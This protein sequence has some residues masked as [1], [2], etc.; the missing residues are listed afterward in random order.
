MAHDHS[1]PQDPKPHSPHDTSPSKTSEHGH[2]CQHHDH[3]HHQHK[4]HEHHDH[5][6]LAAHEIVRSLGQ[7]D[8][9]VKRIRWALFLNGSFAVIELIGG[10][11]TGSYAIVADAVHDFGDALSLLLA[12]LYQK[13]SL[14]AADASYPHGYG[15][16]SIVSSL[17]TGLVIIGGSLLVI[18]GALQSLWNGETRPF[19]PGM[20]A[21]AVLGIVVNGFAALGLA[22]GHSHNE[23]ILTWHL[24]ED[25]LGWVCVLL[26]AVLIYFLHWN[27]IDP[28]LALGLAVFVAYNVLKN[29]KEPY[30][31]ILQKAPDLA[32]QKQHKDAL[33]ALGVSEITEWRSWSLDGF[34]H[35]LTLKL[36]IEGTQ[37]EDL[38]KN[39]IRHY[40]KAHGYRSITIE[41]DPVAS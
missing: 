8:A 20:M 5:H 15:R 32:Q 11:W 21:L 12:L 1:K 29:L 25:V 28:L 6:H 16:F 22:K 34:E 17:I 27:W 31:I 9:S 40:L 37:S 26:G 30:H 4:H 2:S 35:V 10:I 38:I 7:G 23:R 18:L 3:D 39:K 13:K 19:A 41:I 14:R 33:L 24:I 36:T